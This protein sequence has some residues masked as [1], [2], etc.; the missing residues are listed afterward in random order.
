MPW[1]EF[2]GFP[3]SDI[4]MLRPASLCAAGP[5]Q[6]AFSTRRGGVS[7]GRYASLNMGLHVGDRP[8]DVVENRRRFLSAAG[9]E[10]AHMVAAEQVHGD[11][12]CPVDAG[13]RGRGAFDAASALP[14]VDA[15]LTD[16]PGVPLTLYFAD[17]VPVFLFDPCRPAVAVAHAGWKGLASGVIRNTLAAMRRHYHTQPADCRAAVG[18]AIGPCCYEVGPEVVT[19]IGNAGIGSEETA[20]SQKREKHRI[21][22]PGLARL[23]LVASGVPEGSI[24]LSHDCTACRRERF[25]S[26]RRDRTTGR[27]AAAVMLEISAP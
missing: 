16:A 12:P 20:L 6:A 14:G 23:C 22:L 4:A 1:Q 8:E 19:A 3:E 11:I 9:M 2:A 17:C 7:Q 26:F 25:Y 18:P 27:M 24:E 15:L 13:M 10:P 21:D 5:V